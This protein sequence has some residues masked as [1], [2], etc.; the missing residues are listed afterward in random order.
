[1]DYLCVLFL[2]FGSGRRKQEIRSFLCLS[3]SQFAFHFFLPLLLV[4][5]SFLYGSLRGLWISFIYFTAKQK[6]IHPRLTRERK[7]KRSVPLRLGAREGR[8]II[9]AL[10][11]TH[12]RNGRKLLTNHDFGFTARL[13]FISFGHQEINSLEERNKMETS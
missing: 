1:M 7:I 8:F 6:I 11:Q 4:F 13:M 3:G 2:V 12:K 10:I 9:R 5:F